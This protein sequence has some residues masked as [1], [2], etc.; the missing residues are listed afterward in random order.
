MIVKFI[1]KLKEILKIS[2]SEMSNLQPKSIFEELKML[3]IIQQITCLKGIQKTIL[4][5]D[6]LQTLVESERQQYCF[7]RIEL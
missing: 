2:H 3:N 7:K 4:Y 5:F 6:K 1:F